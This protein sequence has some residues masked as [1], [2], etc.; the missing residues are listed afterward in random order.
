MATTL[1]SITIAGRSVDTH[2]DHFG[3]L[4]PSSVDEGFDALRARFAADGYLYLPG[5]HPRN[6]V[7]ACRASVLAQMELEGLFDPAFPLDDAMLKPGVD[8]AF[9]PDIANANPDL[10]GLLYGERMMALASGL[11][12]EAAMHYDYTWMR[13]VGTG[14]STMP[15]YDIVYMGRGT[16]QLFTCWTPLADLEPENGVLAILEGSHQAAELKATYGTMDVDTVCTNKPGVRVVDDKGYVSFGALPEHPDAL[17]SAWGRRWLTNA[18]AMGDVL[19]F[20]MYTLH[21]STDN[22]TPR[23]RLST[24][25]RYQAASLPAD[26][27]WIGEHPV[28]HGES[29][30]IG[31]I[32]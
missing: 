17:R 24:D 20:S 3:A 2:P 22:V 25:S 9:R 7:A 21:A 26:P 11:V 8:I 4:T 10:P 16:D 19:L 29:A 30:Q 15:H 32:C 27:R 1:A 12:G 14:R 13:A 5:F 23:L 18:F 31:M 6:E 28:G